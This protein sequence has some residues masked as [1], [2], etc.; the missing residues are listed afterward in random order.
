MDELAR[1]AGISRAALYLHFPTKEALF[2]ALVERLHDD[3]LAAARAA[4]EAAGP[5][6]A[7]LAAVIEAKSVR[8]FELVQRSAHADEFLDEN[9]R[10]CGELSA[11]ASRAYAGVVARVLK[12]ADAAG[13]ISLAGAGLTAAA[14]AELLLDAL[15][16]LKSRAGPGTT[17]AELRRRAGQLLR[18]WVAGLRPPRRAARGA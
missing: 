11:R 8:L 3:T 13:E 1:G 12:D 4:A 17:S 6:E 10:L 5:L 7:R 9:D 15:E 14:S 2:R 18:V 16:G